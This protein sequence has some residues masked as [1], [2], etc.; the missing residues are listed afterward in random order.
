MF[1]ILQIL[2]AC[3]K[4]LDTSNEFPLPLHSLIR[5]ACA[6]ITGI[7]QFL[8][9]EGFIVEALRDEALRDGLMFS[10]TWLT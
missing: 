7:A 8:R 5:S 2:W 9:A 10:E 6:K 1:G 4:N 3:E